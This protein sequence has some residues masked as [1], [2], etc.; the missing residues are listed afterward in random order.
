MFLLATSLVGGQVR[1]PEIPS[2]LRALVQHSAY[3][4]DDIGEQVYIFLENILFLDTPSVLLCL[5][6][7]FFG[8]TQAAA[9]FS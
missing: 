7:S 4:V 9:A 5:C 3:T 2:A 6:L 8:D 1:S